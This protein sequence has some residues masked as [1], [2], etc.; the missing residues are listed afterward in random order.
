MPV[1]GLGGR[2]AV[3]RLL[4]W[5]LRLSVARLR[6]SVS[7]LSGRLPISGLL[8][9]L[10][11][12]GLLW[13][14]TVARL[15]GRLAVGGLLRRLAVSWLS[16]RLTIARLLRRLPI[17]GLL[18]LLA[19]SRLLP[20]ITLLPALCLR[21]CT[22]IGLSG[23]LKRTRENGLAGF[24]GLIPDRGTNHHT[25]SRILAET[26]INANAIVD[27]VRQFLNQFNRQENFAAKVRL[28]GIV[29]LVAVDE[30]AD[31]RRLHASTGGA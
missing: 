30:K 18:G 17:S 9:R 31:A 26:G 6:L 13:R 29:G 8:G 2:L 25:R 5:L 4:R 20:A 24:L 16:R 1:T 19:I 22:P 7:R 23:A 3:C 28:T 11:I 27:V 14:L 10:P 12:S 21:R 15:S